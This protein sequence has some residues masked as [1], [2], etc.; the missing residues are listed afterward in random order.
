MLAFEGFKHDY[1]VNI[2]ITPQDLINHANAIQFVEKKNS[3]YF[4]VKIFTEKPILEIA[5]SFLKVVISFGM[6]E[7]LYGM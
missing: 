1:L 3:E 6:L 4:K 5:Q 2:R 7:Y